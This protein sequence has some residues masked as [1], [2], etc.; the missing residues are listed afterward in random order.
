LIVEFDLGSDV[1]VRSGVGK[2]TSDN[3]ISA[4]ARPTS[5]LKAIESRFEAAESVDECLTALQSGFGY[6]RVQN[7]V[8]LPDT[9]NLFP[10]L[11]CPS[12][13]ASATGARLQ[14]SSPPLVRHAFPLKDRPQVPFKMGDFVKQKRQETGDSSQE[15]AVRSFD[16]ANAT[17]LPLKGETE[18]ACLFI[19]ENDEDIEAGKLLAIQSICSLALA[20]IERLHQRH[21]QPLG[22]ATLSRLEVSLL[23]GMAKGRRHDEIASDHGV[24]PHTISV[25]SNQIARKLGASSI[26]QAI[27]MTSGHSE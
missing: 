3:E 9:P 17:V 8:L 27:S 15:D 26:R 1:I 16:L 19:V 13:R 4:N 6:F 5:A 7:Y 22:G 2:M 20:K 12:Q 14:S 10:I 18:S 21:D 11:T 23:N 25:F 24:S